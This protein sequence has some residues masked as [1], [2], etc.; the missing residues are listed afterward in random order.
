MWVRF[1]HTG[2]AGGLLGQTIAALASVGAI[3]IVIS[4]M[5]MAWKRIFAGW[6]RSVRRRT[7]LVATGHE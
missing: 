5:A 3:I 2:E 6:I 1:S 7:K 4:G